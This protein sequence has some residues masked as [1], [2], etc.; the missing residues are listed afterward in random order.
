MDK[1]NQISEWMWPICFKYMILAEIIG[2]TQMGVII[3]YSWL[4][5]ET[6]GVN[7]SFHIT[8]LV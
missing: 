6:D 8:K 3:L 2:L 4:I 5:Q 1:P 7:D